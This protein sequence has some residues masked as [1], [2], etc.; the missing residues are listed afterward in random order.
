M[1][2]RHSPVRGRELQVGRRN[3]GRRN[4]QSLLTHIIVAVLYKKGN[5]LSVQ[6]V[7]PVGL[8]QPV[9][10]AGDM[11]EQPAVRKGSAGRRVEHS[12]RGGVMLGNG[13]ED[14]KRRQ[15]RG[16]PGG[17]GEAEDAP[18]LRGDAQRGGRRQGPEHWPEQAVTYHERLAGDAGGCGSDVRRGGLGGRQAVRP[19]MV[20]GGSL[21][22]ETG[23]LVHA[24][25]R[26][27]YPTALVCLYVEDKTL[28][29]KPVTER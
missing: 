20:D 11:A 28:P 15:G 24:W 14:G 29:H 26:P 8:E 12:R 16:H 21:D 22:E 2:T 19:G 17:V 25:R 1:E 13:A 27:P 6:V 10:D 5:P 4:F 23:R 18:P 3:A 9:A 7:P